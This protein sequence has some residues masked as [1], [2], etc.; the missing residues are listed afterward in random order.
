MASPN[1]V[2]SARGVGS[3]VGSISQEY[4]Q[5]CK[6]G[7]ETN[8]RDD[9]V[10]LGD[11]SADGGSFSFTIPSEFRSAN[12]PSGFNPGASRSCGAYARS[13]SIVIEHGIADRHVNFGAGHKLRLFGCE[14]E[15][16]F[17][18][19]N[20]QQ[21]IQLTHLLTWERCSPVL[22]LS[23]LCP[24]LYAPHPITIQYAVR[25]LRS[26]PPNVLMLYIPQVNFQT[27]QQK[28]VNY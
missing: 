5:R 25:C 7:S 1:F 4:C 27:F 12:F 18:F 13:N 28:H 22:A 16:I 10:C 8:E 17:F 26:Y 21:Q 24:R 19:Q 23:L 14:S 2:G 15:Y 11:K 9:K 6:I 3:R 20:Q